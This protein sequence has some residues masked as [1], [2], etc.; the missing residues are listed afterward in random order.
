MDLK[1]I[2]D[3][4]VSSELKNRTW[5]WW[6]WLFFFKS[7]DSEK[8][9]QLM[10]LW[11]TRNCK[12]LKIDDMTWEP[13]GVLKRSENGLEVPG[14]TA[15]WYFDGKRMI[16]PLF[17]EQ[18]NLVSNWT[19]DNAHLTLEN[20]GRCAFSSSNG[21]FKVEAAFEDLSIDLDISKWKPHL[22]NLVPTGKNYFSV[23][24]YKMVKIRA[25]KVEGQMKIKGNSEDVEGTT[26]FQKVRINSPTSPWYFG[27]FHSARGDYIDYFMPHIGSPMLR[28]TARHDSKLYFWEKI[29]SKG[30]HFVEADGKSHNIKNLDMIKEYENDMPIFHLSGNDNGK[31]IEIEMRPYSRACWRVEQPLL[32]V[33]STILHY[34]E[35]PAYVSN[36]KFRDGDREITLEDTGFT[37]GNCEHAWGI[38]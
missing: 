28:R 1:E 2:M 22:Y 36:F 24:G 37:I 6:F 9:K 5:W 38:V 8:W 17:L 11:G 16:D 10:I 33:L 15:A 14:I 35:Y 7:E 21:N 12:K 34:N 18:G 27:T 4:D 29:L 25:C 20:R 3:I 19:K 26:Y 32:R 31:R 30:I 23:L 13:D